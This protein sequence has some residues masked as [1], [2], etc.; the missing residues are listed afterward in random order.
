MVGDVLWR[1]HCRA[2]DPFVQSDTIPAFAVRPERPG[3]KLY[4]KRLRIR[5]R[6]RILRN[7]GSAKT[8]P[9]VL[10]GLVYCS[11]PYD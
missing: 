8:V 9:A 5:L 7:A 2:Y 4:A 3:V 11:Q 1:R 10:F 6:G